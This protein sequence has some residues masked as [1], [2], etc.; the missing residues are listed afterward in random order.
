MRRVFTGLLLLCSL[1]FTPLASHAATLEV[2]A[3][4]SVLLADQTGSL[5]DA[6]RNLWTIK[7]GAIYQ[8]D[9]LAGYSAN[10]I[11]LAYVNNVLWQENADHLWWSWNGFSW[12]GGWGIAQSPLPMTQIAQS[13]T[14]VTKVPSANYSFV[15]D[16]AGD[17][18]DSQLSTWKVVNGVIYKNDTLAGYSA[19]VIR[20][21]TVDN[22]IWHENK[23]HLWWKWNGSNSW[24]GGWGI[25]TSPLSQ[26]VS[27]PQ[28]KIGS[29]VVPALAPQPVSVM[30]QISQP[31]PQPTPLSQL[32][33]SNNPFAGQTLYRADWS[34][35]LTQAQQWRSSRPAD[36]A[37]FDHIAAQPTAMWIGDWN[38]D[39]QKDVA[40]YVS[41]AN[42]ANSL[43]VLVIYNIP[44]RDCG[45][46]SAGGASQ[47]GAYHDWITK[48]A[49]GIGDQKAIIILEPD[50]TALDCF[51]DARG[52]MLT[53]A[54][55]VLEAK[56]NTSVYIDA[57]HPDWVPAD[58]MAARLQ[59]SGI[60]KAQGFALNVSNFY[61]T[62]SNMQYGNDLS[63]RLNGKHYVIDTSRNNNG[64]QGEWCNP[65]GAGIGKVPT[66]N[67][68]HSLYDAG[69]WIKPAGDSDGPC[70]GGPNAG[71]WWPDYALK[72]Y[73]Q[74]TH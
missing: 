8:N 47:A 17:L 10:V 49:N 67:T 30:Q 18:V 29:A 25:P 37:A 35:A 44:F 36:A 33:N 55:N 5:I 52:A 27:I 62:D 19:N 42:Q 63:S 73:R 74:G 66:T 65:Q 59:K 39:I 16:N 70:N 3:Q 14:H 51:D 68:G 23:D 22:V 32:T 56:S 71:A 61:T 40:T 54:V 15:Q 69:L 43:P 26:T 21:A 2:S 60:A 12:D 50:A 34:N 45:S 13:V 41:K 24:D 1:I 46:Y 7:N 48:V 9:V 72:L 64:W 6:Q 31:Q 4:N 20:L 57:G 53:D 11:R 28:L 38:V 58:V